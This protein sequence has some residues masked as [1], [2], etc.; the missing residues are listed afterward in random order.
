M[1]T[2]NVIEHGSPFLPKENPSDHSIVLCGIETHVCVQ[3][4]TF[5]LLERG[6]NVHILADGVSSCNKSD[7]II[8]IDALRQAG[9]FITSTE[10]VLFELMRDSKHPKFKELSS[11]IK[12]ERVETGLI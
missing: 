11:V 7:R 3:Q 9:A 8:A 1:L 4:T 12:E 5:D 6:Y 10:S 2:D